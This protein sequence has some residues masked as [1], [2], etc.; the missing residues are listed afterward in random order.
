[1]HN[2]LIIHCHDLG[3]FLGSYG[4]S[5][6]DTPNL[7]RLASDGTLFE[8]AFATSPH[9]SPARASLFTGTYPQTNGVLGL[10]HAPFHWDLHEPSSHLAHRL[11]RH[12]YRSHLIGVHHES[13]DFDDDE[14]ARRLGFTSVRTGGHRDEVVQ[15][16]NA[17]LS[18]AATSGSPFYL[19]VGFDEP[20]RTPSDQ[21]E[22][23]V[24]GFLAEGVKAESSRGISIPPYLRD[25]AGAREEIAELQG[26]VNFMDQGVGAI[27]DHLALLGLDRNT[28]L[29]FTTDHGLALPRAKC[30]LYDSG[31]GVALMMRVPGRDRWTSRRIPDLVSHVDVLPT[32]LELVGLGVDDDIQGESLVPMVEA[33]EAGRNHVFGQF[34]Y[35][36]YYDPKRAVRSTTHKLIVNFS[37]APSVMDP[38]QSWMHRSAPVQLRGPT[39]P[40]SEAFELYELN[41]D[42]DEMEN[43]AACPEHYR[44]LG[45]LARALMGWMQESQDPLLQL[46][47]ASPRHR[48]AMAALKEAASTDDPVEASHQIHPTSA[49][50]VLTEP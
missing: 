37:N 34:S 19:Q 47:I 23:G 42:P 30:T 46:Q 10:A 29:V 32:L 45:E 41:N 21:D 1:M 15:R 38:T 11:G 24:M 7:D 5:G 13:R 17:A 48:L 3:R 39:V 18:A 33:S 12:G 44:V 20:H 4:I 14:V 43:L 36:T 31:L 8:A 50:P 25:D 26:A 22:A 9:C 6:V 2:I 16:T 35:H 27:L 40:T 49:V 28:I